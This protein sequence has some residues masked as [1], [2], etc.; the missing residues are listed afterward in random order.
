MSDFSKIASH[1]ISRH[2][3][4]IAGNSMKGDLH[5]KLASLLSDPYAS[6]YILGCLSVDRA[7]SM[8]YEEADW[9]EEVQKQASVGQEGM[10]KG[11]SDRLRL[12]NAELCLAEFFDSVF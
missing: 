5:D 4:E 10:V 3:I 7:S 11:A 12:G 2:G 8:G 6:G 1:M 9:V